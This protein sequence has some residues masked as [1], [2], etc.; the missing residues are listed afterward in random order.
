MSWVGRF[1]LCRRERGKRAL[2]IAMLRRRL[3]ARGQI[4]SPRMLDINDGKIV[5]VIMLTREFGP[6]STRLH[7]YIEG[8]NADEAASLVAVMWVGRG[9]FEAEMVGG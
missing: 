8:L 3:E 6:D 9:S 5:R 1:L 4:R 2:P 7:D